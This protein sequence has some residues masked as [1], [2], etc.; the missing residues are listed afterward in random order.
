MSFSSR[1]LGLLMA[2]CLSMA[3]MHGLPVVSQNS[4]QNLLSPRFS[5]DPLIYNGVT[6]GSTPLSALAGAQTIKGRCQGFATDK[7]NH[8]I[9]LKEPFGFLSLK[10]FSGGDITLLV[11][12]PDGI[13][14]RD[15]PNP[16]LSGAWPAGEYQVWV[17]SKS[18]DRTQYRLSISETRQ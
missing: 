13:Y 10:V 16:E 18:G 9:R 1:Q 15:E 5:P 11:K 7:P 12:G 2:T 8:K 3:V 4:S 17:G 14:C 6:S